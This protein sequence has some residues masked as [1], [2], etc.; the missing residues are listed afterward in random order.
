[1]LEMVGVLEDNVE[2]SCCWIEVRTAEGRTRRAEV[3][4]G[5][6][7]DAAAMGAGLNAAL[8]E[9]GL[10]ELATVRV[11]PTLRLTLRPSVHRLQ[12]S[13]ALASVLSLPKPLFSP[14]PAS[15]PLTFQPFRPLTDPLFMVVSPQLQRNFSAD[16]AEHGVLAFVSLSAATSQGGFTASNFIP[17]QPCCLAD[18]I[19]LLRQIDFY[20]H[21][22]SSS[23]S[24]VGRFSISNVK[25]CLIVSFD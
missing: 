5:F 14:P 21:P 18:S 12:F 1:M 23:D 25:A 3:E 4:S 8:A 16:G 17:A 7:A 13:P 20:L 15:I 22:V 9:A 24:T 2:K 10:A 19:Q 11:D 6:Y